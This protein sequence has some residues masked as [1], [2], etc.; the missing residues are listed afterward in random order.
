MGG[1]DADRPTDFEQTGEHEKKPGHD[2][3]GT[4]VN[5][6]N[7]GRACASKGEKPARN[8]LLPNGKTST[9]QKNA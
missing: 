9:N 5:R 1:F 2:N 4:K 7:R 8:S 3:L 6:E